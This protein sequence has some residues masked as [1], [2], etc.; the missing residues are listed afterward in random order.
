MKGRAVVIL[1][2]NTTELRE[3]VQV[4]IRLIAFECC[5]SQ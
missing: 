2:R 1:F 5:S 4:G 3:S